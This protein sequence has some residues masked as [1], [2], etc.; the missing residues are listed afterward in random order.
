M[1]RK[2]IDS[3]PKPR[4]LRDGDEHTSLSGCGT[5]HLCEHTLI[6]LDVLQDIKGR[7][8]IE[9]A[10][11]WKP[12][13]VQLEDRNL[14]HT[15]TGDFDRCR[16]QFPARDTQ[17]RTARVQRGENEPGPA[18]D[19]EK[20]RRVRKVLAQGPHNQIV[21]RSKP[22]ASNLEFREQLERLVRDLGFLIRGEPEV[23]LPR[24]LPAA[25]RTA[26]LR[27]FEGRVAREAELQTASSFSST[28]VT[29]STTRSTS[30][31]VIPT[32]S[33]KRTRRSLTSSVTWRGSSMRPY[34]RPARDEW[35]GT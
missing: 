5:R 33:G 22:K 28:E 12:S 7:N 26:P 3:A 20:T 18:T 32:Q 23:R 6:V 16:G 31:A 34:R 14:R 25:L 29:A 2:V 13:R 17:T 35:S 24:R 8:D 9:L 21:T 15:R 1:P 10:F 4:M 30:L 11:E 19:L 27:R